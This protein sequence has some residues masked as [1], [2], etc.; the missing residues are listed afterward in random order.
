MSF[1][2]IWVTRPEPGNATTSAALQNAGFEVIGLPVLDVRFVAPSLPADRPDWIVFVSANAV[3]GL[4][5]AGVP[6]GFRGKVRAAAVGSRSALVAAGDGWKVELVPKREN[7]EGL[8][9]TFGHI[10]LNGL[11]VWIPG[12]NREGSASRLLPEALRARGAE[13]LTFSVYETLDRDLKVGELARLDAADPGLIVFH[14]PSAVETVYSSAGPGSVRRWQK[15]DLVAIGSTTVASCRRVRTDRIWESPEPSDT[16][17]V[18]LITSL[19]H[20]IT[21]EKRA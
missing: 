9:E 5:A 14:S 4:E 16:A 17:L 10:D 11:Q 1:R 7:A 13:V 2:T 18:T 19:T 6:A 3:R 21:E 8:L 20:K 12:G 15:A